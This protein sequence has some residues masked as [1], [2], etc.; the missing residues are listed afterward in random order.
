MESH[1][2]HL[3]VPSCFD[4]DDGDVF[5]TLSTRG[6]RRHRRGHQ[7]AAAGSSFDCR[8]CGREFPTSF[9]ALGGHRTS[10]L[11]RPPATTKE[12]PLVHT[13][14]ACGLGFSTGQALGGHMRRHRGGPGAGYVV[15]LTWAVMLHERPSSTAP[16]Q[17]LDLFV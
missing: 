11:R 4:D 10:H 3:H 16:L 9:Q 6:R 1:I 2:N 12:K 8:T 15:D 5:L 13:C 17:L 14:A 7:Q